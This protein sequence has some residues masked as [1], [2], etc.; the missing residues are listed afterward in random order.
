MLVQS[1][2]FFKLALRPAVSPN[3]KSILLENKKKLNYTHTRLLPITSSMTAE[4]T[5][6][7]RTRQSQKKGNTNTVPTKST[8]Q[9][10]KVNH[11]LLETNQRRFTI[12]H[13]QREF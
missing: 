13:T 9:T 6:Q 2:P 5:C 3:Y 11:K 4:H 1:G 8:K 12:L 10:K 7:T